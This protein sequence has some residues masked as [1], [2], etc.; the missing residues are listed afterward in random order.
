MGTDHAT[1][2]WLGA[3]M[4]CLGLLDPAGADAMAPEIGTDCQ[5]CQYPSA[6][7]LP[8]CSGVYMGNGLVLTAAHC[9]SNVTANSKAYFGEHESDWE[10]GIDIAYCEAHPDGESDSGAWGEDSWSGPDLA[11]CVLEEA[12][13]MPPVVPPMM[14]NGCERDWLA[15][16][17]YQTASHATVVAVGTGCGIHQEYVGQDC[18]DGTKRFAA[19]QLVRQTS[20]NG[21]GTK[22]ELVRELWG[23]DDT[24]IRSGDSGG[25]VFVRLPDDTLR[26]IGVVHGTTPGE[27][28][29]EAVPPYL[30]WIESASGI[31]VTPHHSFSNGS[32]VKA[33]GSAIAPQSEAAD[34]F[35]SWDFGCAGHPM[36][37]TLSYT[38]PPLLGGIQCPGWPKMPGDLTLGLPAHR[39]AA[40]DKALVAEPGGT[41]T[42]PG[43]ASNLAVTLDPTT[44]PLA[45]LPV[46]PAPTAPLQLRAPVLRTR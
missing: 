29:A 8:L 39:D 38:E 24:G 7:R 21:S 25:P 14:P 13:V 40:A 31:D 45:F 35:G 4:L 42:S 27:A 19:Q 2:S 36:K 18:E 12:V 11:F 33:V 28:Y 6:V 41:P 17:V 15:H 3:A 30:H 32:W 43:A 44:A 37:P 34:W 46:E 23:D 26:L 10:L 1:R 20:H 9:I 22:L 16:R 5:D